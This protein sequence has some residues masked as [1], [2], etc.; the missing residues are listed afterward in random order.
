M[1]WQY[2]GGVP[3][4][5]G[6][7]LTHLSA[8]R[9]QGLEIVAGVDAD[10]DTLA[11]FVAHTGI[12]AHQD[13]SE[14]L[15]LGPEVATIA[16]P[17]ALHGGHL[18]ECLRAGV[19]RIWLEKPAT[20]DIAETLRLANLAKSCGA[21][22]LVGFQRRYMNSYRRLENADLGLLKGVSITY[23]RGLRTNGAHMVDLALSVLGDG[24]VTVGDVVPGPPPEHVS[25]AC[26]SFVL[27]GP[28]GVPAT[29]LGMDLDHHSIDITVHRTRGRRSVLYGGVHT[30]VDMVVPNPLFPGYFRLAPTSKGQHDG[31]A[32]TVFPMMLRDLLSDGPAQPLSNLDTAAAGQAIIDEVLRRC[33]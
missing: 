33:G 5:S 25:E 4:S 24:D 7:A 23:S 26:P 10:P 31:E 13:L 8:L 15:S 32:S 29:V 27:R 14:A 18:S 28:E 6:G 9:S 11:S 22:V 3:T 19:E 16:S 1:A 17:N 21:R 2:D 20:T 12:S 30:Q